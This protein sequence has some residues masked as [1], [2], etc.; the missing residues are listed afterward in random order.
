MATPPVFSAG[1]VLTAAQMNAVGLWDVNTTTL[2]GNTNIDNVF[3]SDYDNYRVVLSG[4]NNSSTT[5]AGFDMAMRTS[6]TDTT[7]NYYSQVYFQYGA[8]IGGMVSQNAATVFRLGD[9]SNSSPAGATF[10][11]DLLGP[12]AALIT[13]FH[14][15]RWAYQSN[16]ATFVYATIAGCMNTSTQY[17]GIRLSLTTGTLTG[18]CRIYGYRN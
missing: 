4:L 12:Q 9:F 14:G 5:T 3:T 15:H 2:N 18:T 1:A 11:F 16:V 7:A 6:T 17:T 13:T 10:V 8:A